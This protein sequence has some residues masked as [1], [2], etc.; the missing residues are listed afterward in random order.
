MSTAVAPPAGMPLRTHVRELRQ[1]ATRATVAIALGVVVGFALSGNLLDIV[2]VPIEQ[3][4]ATRDASLNYTSIT[5]AFDLRLRVALIAGLALSSPVWIAEIFGF[6][7]PG[8]TRREK[9][10]LF[11]FFA[12][13]LPLF[14]VGATF[15][16]ALFPH[17]VELLSSF[18]AA[19]DSTVLDASTYVDFVL[20]IVVVC[21]IA[22]VAPVLL[23]LLNALGILPAR[24]IARNWRWV[25]VAIVLFSA[26]AT[27][28]ADILSMFVVAVPLVALF[29]GAW[30]VAAVH[31]RLDARRNSQT[32]TSRGEARVRTHG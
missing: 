11:G 29:V 8:L 30:A 28:A 1:R 16:L 17:M 20:K 24:T 2:R 7:A 5:G 26:I 14:I 27:P 12:A 19:E 18:A 9:R 32:P 22:F 4:A 25:V 23:V 6:V 31:D 21:G 3:I 13:A 10:Y 15:G